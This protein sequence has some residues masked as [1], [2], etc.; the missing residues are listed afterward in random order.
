MK[1]DKYKELIMYLIVG[2]LTTVVSLGTYYLLTL[3]LLNPN[4]D[5]Q[6][7]VANVLSWIAAVIF[8]YVTNKKYVF[9]S[10]EKDVIK[11]GSKFLISRIFTLLLDMFAMF[12]MVSI[13]H[14]YDRIAKLISQI[15]V[16]IA[17]YVI[18]KLYVFTKKRK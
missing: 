3:S 18:S 4:N 5:V 1:K 12:L 9:K 14:F 16:I 11:E 8:A 17:N 6:L 13:L 10:E 7:Q 2:V 15:L